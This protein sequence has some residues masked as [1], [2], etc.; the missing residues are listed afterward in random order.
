MLLKELQRYS[1]FSFAD[2]P[3]RKYLL[4]TNKLANGNCAIYYPVYARD[5]ALSM[6]GK[7]GSNEVE[8]IDYGLYEDFIK[9]K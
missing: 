5:K 8:V 1:V 7:Y 6:N 4:E 3:K 2:S 9:K